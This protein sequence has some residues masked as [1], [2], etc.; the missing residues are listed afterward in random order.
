MLQFLIVRVH[1][2]M[3]PQVIHGGKD[4]ILL[5]QQRD[6]A[7]VVLGL[8]YSVYWRQETQN[9]AFTVPP[10]FQ[11]ERFCVKLWGPSLK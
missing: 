3:A 1:V 6:V 5:G 8:M 11:W 2:Q 7:A 9:L 10:V 4:H